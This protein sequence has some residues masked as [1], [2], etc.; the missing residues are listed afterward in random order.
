MD[1]KLDPIVLMSMTKEQIDKLCLEM[2]IKDTEGEGFF[3][4]DQWIEYQ[5][6]REDFYHEYVEDLINEQLAKEENQ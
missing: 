5:T 3:S 2:S 6:E 1:N 4:K